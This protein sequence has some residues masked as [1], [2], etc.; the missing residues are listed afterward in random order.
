MG[1]PADSPR[2]YPARSLEDGP[3]PP[4][5]PARMAPRSQPGLF[6]IDGPTRVDVPLDPMV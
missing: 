6:I 4:C 5:S 3:L 2:V 1:Y